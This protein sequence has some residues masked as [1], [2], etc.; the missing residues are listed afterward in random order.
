MLNLE[1]RDVR[2]ERS[3]TSNSAVIKGEVT[4]KTGRNYSSVAIRV[5]FFMKNIA[6]VN[7]VLSLNGLSSN[8]TKVFEKNVEDLEFDAVAKDITNYEIYTE[9]AY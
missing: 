1:Y 2:L 3:K 9:S 7:I 5:I 6:V 8:A 4:N